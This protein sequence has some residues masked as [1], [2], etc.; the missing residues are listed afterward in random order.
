MVFNDGVS[1][2]NKCYSC[3]LDMDM[4]LHKACSLLTDVLIGY[5][6]FHIS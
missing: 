5:L 1:Q 4:E 6:D 2:S 3:I